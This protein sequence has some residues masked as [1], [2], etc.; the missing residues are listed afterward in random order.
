VKAADLIQELVQARELEGGF[1][2]VA[3]TVHPHPTFSEA[4]MEAARATDGWL[5]HG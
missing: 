3:R 2:E 4:V 5:I 1:P